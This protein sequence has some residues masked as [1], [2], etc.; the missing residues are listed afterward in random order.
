MQFS[1]TFH[2]KEPWFVWTMKNKNY[3]MFINL[4]KF[5]KR[6]VYGSDIVT[7]I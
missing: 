3:V 5:S 7:E 1:T 2:L 4:K 6:K